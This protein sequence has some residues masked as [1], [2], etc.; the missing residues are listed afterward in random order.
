MHEKRALGIVT[1]LCALLPVAPAAAQSLVI[2]ALCTASA[3]FE[4]TLAAL[5]LGASTVE[6]CAMPGEEDA[7]YCAAVAELEVGAPCADALGS[8]LEVGAELRSVETLAD[9]RPPPTD[10]AAARPP[11]SEIV[12]SR[13]AASGRVRI[14]GCEFGDSG[15]R[16]RFVQD[17]HAPPSSGESCATALESAGAEAMSLTSGGGSLPTALTPLGSAL[18]ST[19]GPIEEGG[20]EGATGFPVHRYVLGFEKSLGLD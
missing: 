11:A 5:D 13:I 1:A 18:T 4:P 20:G 7:A 14:V 15:P 8:L 19:F 6:R 12:Y 3:D 2:V 10:A 9:D 17:S 16:A